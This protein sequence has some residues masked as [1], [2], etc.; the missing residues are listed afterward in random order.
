MVWS[1]AEVAV[2]AVVAVAA[3]WGDFGGGALDKTRLRGSRGR[4]YGRSSLW[5]LRGRSRAKSQR[6]F[7][8]SR[9][10]AVRR[11]AQRGPKPRGDSQPFAA[12]SRL[13]MVLML[14]FTKLRAIFFSRNALLVW[15][16]DAPAA[17]ETD[18]LH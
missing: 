11:V 8:I 10:R 17:L 6:V 14:S 18:M 12:G 1:L 16:E 2:V 9:V 13:F 5:A 3:P 4:V 7:R 15:L